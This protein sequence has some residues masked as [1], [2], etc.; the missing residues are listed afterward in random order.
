MG[1]A[2]LKQRERGGEAEP[3]STV[4]SLNAPV[5]KSPGTFPEGEKL[6]F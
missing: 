5:N 3:L 4:P 2:Y 1:G 6:R